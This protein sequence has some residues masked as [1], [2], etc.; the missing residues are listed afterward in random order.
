MLGPARPTPSNF[1]RAIPLILRLEGGYTNHGSDPGG[2][3]KYGISK[4]AYPDLIIKDLTKPQAAV[5]YRRDY[6]DKSG[7]EALPWPLALCHFD[8]AVNHGLGRATKFLALTKEPAV[9]LGL[10]EAFYHRIVANRPASVAFLKGW[11]N[12]LRAV[13][14]EGGIPYVPR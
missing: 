3:T 4:R 14:E 12:R 5:I 2:E 9:Y 10:R 6:W 11:L 8:A 13:A 1:D 7:C